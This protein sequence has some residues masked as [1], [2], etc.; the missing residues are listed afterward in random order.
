[1]KRKE[2]NELKTK[3]SADLAKLV[4]KKREDLIKVKRELLEGKEKNSRLAKLI[5]HEIAQI[6]TIKG[7]IDRETKKEDTK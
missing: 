2:L 3:P 4:E 5:R 7:I 1:M 6:L